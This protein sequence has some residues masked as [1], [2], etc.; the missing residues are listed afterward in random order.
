MGYN[1]RRDGPPAWFITL[2]AIAL[3]FGT[4]Y[5]WINLQE[6][7]RVGGLS[8]AEAT[9]QAELNRTA[10]QEQR[11]FLATSLPTR[12]PTATSRPECLDFE[13]IADTGNLRDDPTTQSDFIGSLPNGTV[14]CVLGTRRGEGNFIWYLL[15]RDPLTRRIEEAFIREDIVRPLNPT[16]TPRPTIPRTNTPIPADTHTPAPATNTPRPSNT[17][18]PQIFPTVTPMPSITATTPGIGI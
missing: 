8:I 18:E 10:T 5:A 7:M 3:I 11:I 14:I 17:P 9:R 2:L 4:Y 16:S 15:D 1:T 12:R 13:V 6:F